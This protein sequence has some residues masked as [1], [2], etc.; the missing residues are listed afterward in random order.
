MYYLEISEKFNDIPCKVYGDTASTAK[1]ILNTYLD[2]TVSTG[3]LLVGEKGSGK[4]MLAKLLSSNAVLED[5]PT[6]IINSAFF[7]DVFNKFIQD[8]SQRCIV[9][10]DEFEKVYDDEAQAHI[11]TLLDGVFPQK[12]LFIVT[13]ND[14]WKLNRNLKN[15]PGRIF[16]RLEYEGLDEAFVREYLA[17]NLKDQSQTEQV[18]QTVTSLFDSFNFDMMLAIVQEMNRYDEGIVDTLKF[19]NAKPASSS[20]V[21]YAVALTVNGKSIAVSPETL[22]V[23]IWSTDNSRSVYPVRTGG[24]P[25]CAEVSCAGQENDTVIDFNTELDLVPSAIISMNI[26]TGVYTY[27]IAEFEITLTKLNKMKQYTYLDALSAAF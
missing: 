7:G 17:D 15:R 23:D 11:L 2:R 18:V 10:F 20:A 13:C 9:M 19:I 22:R 14:E 1:R 6:L 21:G 24:Q 26:Q 3:V 25:G 12:K 16:Y 8:I 4:T 5:I 27:R